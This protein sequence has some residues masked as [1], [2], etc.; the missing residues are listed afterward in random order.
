MTKIYTF[1][2]ESQNCAPFFMEW[3]E[4]T[5][6]AARKQVEW[7]TRMLYPDAKVTCLLNVRDE[8]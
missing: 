6:E 5:E 4:E 1:G 3:Q 7:R 2:I 8:T